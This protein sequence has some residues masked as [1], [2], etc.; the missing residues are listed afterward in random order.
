MLKSALEALDGRLQGRKVK[1]LP[2]GL[3]LYPTA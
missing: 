2:G 1:K 3:T